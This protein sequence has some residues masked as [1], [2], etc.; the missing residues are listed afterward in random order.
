V[1]Q[2]RSQTVTGVTV[3]KNKERF[4]INYSFSES[5]LAIRCQKW[6]KVVLFLPSQNGLK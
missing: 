5:T 1:R 2:G 4:Y 3:V 6:I